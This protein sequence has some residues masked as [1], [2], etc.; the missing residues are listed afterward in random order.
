MIEF[1][2]RGLLSIW[3]GIF[4]QVIRLCTIIGTS[5]VD[6]VIYKNQKGFSPCWIQARSIQLKIHSVIVIPYL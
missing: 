1:Q 2:Y 5:L 3:A 4:N 6:I